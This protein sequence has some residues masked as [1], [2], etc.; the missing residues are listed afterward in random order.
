MQSLTTKPLFFWLRPFV[1]GFGLLV[2]F[3]SLPASESVDFAR[4]VRPILARHCFKCHG[5]DDNKRS[6]GLRL[7]TA[8]GALGETKSGNRAV[9]PENTKA[10]E[11]VARIHSDDPTEIMP[12]PDTKDPLTPENKQILTRW[13]ASGGQY[14]EHWS[15]VPPQNQPPAITQNLPREWQKNPIDAFIFQK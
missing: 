11:L 6:A 14:S 3:E 7:D 15:F 4:D 9:V 2:S 8:A 13:I 5:P 10:S 12:P 1:I